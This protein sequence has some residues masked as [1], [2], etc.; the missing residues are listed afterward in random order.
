MSDLLVAGPPI[1]A[2]KAAALPRTVIVLMPKTDDS[3]MH[4]AP[5]RKSGAKSYR[6]RARGVVLGELVVVIDGADGVVTRHIGRRY[7]IL[8]VSTPVAAV[9]V[10]MHPQ[11]A[12]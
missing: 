6:L 12:L 9:R 1:R 7:L 8:P 3:I 5:V 11:Y 10:S 4:Q 2:L